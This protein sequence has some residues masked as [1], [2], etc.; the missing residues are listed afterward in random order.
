MKFIFYS[1]NRE[2]CSSV[3]RCVLMAGF[4]MAKLRQITNVFWQRNPQSNTYDRTCTITLIFQEG[5][6]KR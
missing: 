4:K 6:R 1:S 5:F 2:F 3:S